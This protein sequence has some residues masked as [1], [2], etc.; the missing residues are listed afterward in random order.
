MFTTV[1]SIRSTATEHHSKKSY[2]LDKFWF[3]QNVLCDYNAD[4]TALETAPVITMS[5]L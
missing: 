3:D 5:Y 2:R 1:Y 4:L